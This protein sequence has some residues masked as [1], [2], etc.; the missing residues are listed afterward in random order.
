MRAA[1]ALLLSVSGCSLLIDASSLSEDKSM[2]GGAG[3][4]NAGTSNAGTSNAGTSG[5]EPELC[6]RSCDGLDAEC[7]PTLDEP[8]CPVGCDGQVLNGEPYLGCTSSASFSAAEVRCAEQGMHLMR[9]DSAAE[10]AIA[11]ELAQSL[12]SYVWIGGSDLGTLGTFTW[13][14]GSAFLR[15]SA[16]ISGVYQNFAEGEPS[17]SP[18][19]H[20]VQLHNDAAGPWSTA[21]C[22]DVKQFICK[23][24]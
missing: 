2:T 6:A 13:P 3:T 4:S 16:P 9:I 11:V 1:L 23:R 5:S 7:R 10:N 12:G 14:D 18:G 24:Y 17:A 8:E 21:P 19:R 20:C 22:N 15:D